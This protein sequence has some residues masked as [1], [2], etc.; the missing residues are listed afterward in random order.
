V[1]FDGSRHPGNRFSLNFR[2]HRKIVVV[3]GE[4]AWVGGLNI[5]REYVGMDPDLGH[6]RD[7][8]VCV[9][10]PAALAVQAVVIEDWL[11]ATG[12]SLE[13]LIC[14]PRSWEAN[15]SVLVAP[16]SPAS[17]IE[18]CTL[19]FMELI[20][21][22][23]HRLWIASPYFVPDEQF[24]SQLQ[25]AAI[26]GVDVRIMLPSRPDHR[27]VQLASYAF[28]KPLGDVGVK[29]FRYTKGF[30]H[31]KVMLVDDSIGS[32]GSVNFD[33][34]SFRLNFEISILVNDLHFAR[35][36]GRMLEADFR[37]CKPLSHELLAQR[38]AMFNLAVRGAKLLAPVL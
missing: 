36:I 18:T 10:G 22:S 15:Q 6:W 7:T 17:N 5:G 14:E 2:N 35:E 13:S 24:V 16:T 37:H 25:L 8:H 38:G 32:I 27:L 31:Q 12:E 33:N 19:L 34:R 9:R 26:R 11:W 29:F 30:L 4:C 3:D 1:A 21:Q 28:L 23:Q 20:R